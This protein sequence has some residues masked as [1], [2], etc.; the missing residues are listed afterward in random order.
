[1]KI[2]SYS[3][4]RQ[5][6][7]FHVAAH[8]SGML[9]NVR[10]TVLDDVVKSYE[11]GCCNLDLKSG[12]L[13]LSYISDITDNEIAII[14]AFCSG[15]RNETLQNA[16]EILAAVEKCPLPFGYSPYIG[17]ASSRLKNLL[18]DIINSIP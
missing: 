4:N 1:M 14:N 9:R 12:K 18:D 6:K 10:Q 3:R 7:M 15:I 8:A 17:T 11:D 13:I 2:G 16:K 5:A